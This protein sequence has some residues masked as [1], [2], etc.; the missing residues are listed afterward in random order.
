[1][2]PNKTA[3]FLHP[4]QDFN[5][6]WW[7]DQDQESRCLFYKTRG[8]ATC[9]EEKDYIFGLIFFLKKYIEIRTISKQDRWTDGL[10]FI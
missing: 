4:I 7:Q 3:L 10:R 5:L 2:T 9:N 1:M 6:I 8:E